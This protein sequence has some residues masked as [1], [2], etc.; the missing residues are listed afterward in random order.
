MAVRSDVLGEP[1]HPGP[2]V[3]ASES[4]KSFSG[5]FSHP[6]YDGPRG[7]VAPVKEVSV[8]YGFPKSFDRCHG[9][10]AFRVSVKVLP[11]C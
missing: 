5:L 2:G 10:P 7:S 4:L 11:L 8:S 6:L 9:A 1:H 3:L